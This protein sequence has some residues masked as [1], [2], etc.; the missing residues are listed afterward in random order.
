MTIYI[1]AAVYVLL[2][3]A[4]GLMRAASKPIPKMRRER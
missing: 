4:L 3:L 2:L 1:L